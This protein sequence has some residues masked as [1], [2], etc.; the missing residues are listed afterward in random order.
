M[1]NII[2]KPYI[3]TIG[4]L[5]KFAPERMQLLSPSKK[6][7]IESLIKI[8]LLNEKEYQTEF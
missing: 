3:Q 4:D 6:K 7:E 5:I 8:K 1:W 2:Y